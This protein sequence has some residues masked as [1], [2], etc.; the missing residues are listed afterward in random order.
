MALAAAQEMLSKKPEVNN[1][2]TE[3]DP[4]DLKSELH[5]LRSSHHSALVELAS[6]R[7]AAARGQGEA[8]QKAQLLRR[9]LEAE[10]QHSR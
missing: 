5:T 7:T 8:E 10:R 6:L 1:K 2:A 3:T 9:E 4:P